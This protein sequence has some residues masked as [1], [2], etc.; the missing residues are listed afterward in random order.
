MKQHEPVTVVMCP[1]AQCTCSSLDTCTCTL[2]TWP[3]AGASVH[4]IYTYMCINSDCNCLLFSSCGVIPTVPLHW[5]QQ[6]PQLPPYTHTHTHTQHMY[7]AHACT[8]LYMYMYEHVGNK[9]T[10]EGTRHSN[11][12]G[13]FVSCTL[14]T[15]N[16]P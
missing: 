8:S 9:T 7:T 6:I 3:T 11:R 16:S 1:H 12:S 4:V 2:R 5:L 15:C 10:D 14:I 13:D